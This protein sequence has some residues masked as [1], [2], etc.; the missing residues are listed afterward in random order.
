MTSLP[1]VPLLPLLQGNEKAEGIFC[2]TWEPP[3]K[4][5]LFNWEIT[6]SAS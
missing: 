6:V 4:W 2:G 3:Q 5:P 1:E